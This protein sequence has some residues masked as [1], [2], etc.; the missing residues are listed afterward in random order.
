[1]MRPYLMLVLLCIGRSATA[2]TELDV[3]GARFTV[4]GKP[5]FLLGASY[6]GALGASREFVQQ[7]LDD[8]RKVRINW[9]RVFATW[10]AFGNNVSAIGLQAFED[11]GRLLDS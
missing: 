5:T 3:E 9:I 2:A 1:M 10:G 7:D 6:Y 8:M 11:G 4:N